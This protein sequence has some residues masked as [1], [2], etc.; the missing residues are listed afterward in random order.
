MKIAILSDIHGNDFALKAVLKDIKKCKVEQLFILGDIVG[1]YYNPH[2]VLDLLSDWKCEMIRG[3]HENILKSLLN[4]D[5]DFTTVHNLY[6]S[7]HKRALEILS[8][9]QLNLLLKLPDKKSLEINESKFLLCHGSPWSPDF[10][11][12]P[13][14][15]KDILEKCIDSIHDFI[16]IGHSHYQFAVNIGKQILINVGSVGQSRQKGGVANWALVNTVNNSFELKSTR[17]NTTELEKEISQ[18]DPGN[19]YLLEILKR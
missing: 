9:Q 12:Y 5:L 8:E 7:G 1:Y 6:G 18:N 2:K 16:L 19:N 13:D 17:Y 15:K 3:N 10:Y 14:T 4:S 11:I